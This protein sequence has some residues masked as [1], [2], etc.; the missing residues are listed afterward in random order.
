MYLLNIQSS[1][2]RSRSAS[3]AVADAFVDAYCQISPDIIVDTLNVWEENLPEFDQEAIGAKYKGINQEA[4]NEVEQN[5]WDRIQELVA[6]FKRADRIVIGVPMWNFAY[7]YKLK[8]L[9]DLVAQRNLLFTYDGRE[10]GPLLKTPRALLIL[11]RGGAFAEDLPTPPSRFDHQRGYLEF[12][13]PLVGVQEVKTLV[14]ETT[15]WRGEE[16]GKNSVEQGKATARK[17]AAHF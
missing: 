9:I 11:T 15:S 5:V 4:M 1:P 16:K 3:I 14:V 13:L 6:R 10:Y 2:R 7:P 12:W 8:Q 17:L